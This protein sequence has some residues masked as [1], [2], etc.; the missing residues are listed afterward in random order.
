MRLARLC[1]LGFVLVGACHPG[2]SAPPPPQDA[3]VFDLAVDL[4]PGCPPPT[5]NEKGVGI[6]CTRGGG[7]CSKSGVPGGLR[8]TCDPLP[9]LKVVLN[10]VPCICTIGGPNISSTNPDPCAAD[11]VECGSDATCC[12]YLKGAYYCMPN[13][14]LP[15]GVCID[16]TSA[17]GGW[18]ARS[19]TRAGRVPQWQV[20][21][22]LGVVWQPA[23][24]QQ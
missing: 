10:G 17:N 14:C 1:W 19:V 11:N 16:F 23:A 3:T 5:P 8:C 13:I 2:S 24:E 15:G 12:P 20:G 9:F 21:S 18:P 4:P 7:E 22:L 6:L